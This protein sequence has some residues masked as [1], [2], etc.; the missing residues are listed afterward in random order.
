MKKQ[1]KSQG[2]DPMLLDPFLLLGFSL[3]EITTFAIVL[4]G[5]KSLPLVEGEIILITIPQSHELLQFWFAHTHSLLLCWCRENWNVNDKFL[6][7]QI[8]QIWV[9]KS[10]GQPSRRGGP[11]IFVF[12]ILEQVLKVSIREK[13]PQALVGGEEN[14][15]FKVFQSSPGCCGSVDW[16]VVL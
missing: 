5:L 9:I 6:E 14:E 4:P 16:S 10:P 11:Y 2:T 12:D 7:A 13:S 3:C 15:P 8:G 1:R